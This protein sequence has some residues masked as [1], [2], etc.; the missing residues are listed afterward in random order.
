MLL[1]N[2]Y[3]DPLNRRLA[4]VIVAAVMLFLAFLGFC[5]SSVFLE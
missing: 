1:D 2:I 4:L 5:K 3:F